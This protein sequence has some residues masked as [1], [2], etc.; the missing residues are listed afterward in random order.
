MSGQDLHREDSADVSRN[1][2][3]QLRLRGSPAAHTLRR[4]P[5]SPRPPRNGGARR[6]GGLRLGTT[7]GKPAASRAAALNE[8]RG[9]GAP[10]HNGPIMRPVAAAAPTVPLAARPSPARRNRF[11]RIPAFTRRRSA[12]PRAPCQG[13]GGRAPGRSRETRLRLRLA[14]SS[15]A[16]PGPPAA[17]GCGSPVGRASSGAGLPFRRELA[18]D[19]ALTG[20]CGARR[21]LVQAAPLPRASRVRGL[22]R[23]PGPVAVLLGGDPEGATHDARRVG[24]ARSSR[25]GPA[26][27]GGPGL[28]RRTGSLPRSRSARRYGA[29]GLL[30]MPRR[31]LKTPSEST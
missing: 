29:S 13:E 7:P 11:R 15:F 20:S 6:V 28:R 27:T 19:A 23:R 16:S 2:V 14:A 25:P 8:T 31:C 26:S 18:P 17:R 9:T 3:T 24:R 21:P 4:R 10:S 1:P 12:D 30:C 5:F 22:T